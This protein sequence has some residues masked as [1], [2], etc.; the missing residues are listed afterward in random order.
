M[1]RNVMSERVLLVK[2][3]RRNCML[4]CD[5]LILTLGAPMQAVS[6]QSGRA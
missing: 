2:D 5:I 3:L 1:A 4:S 6:D